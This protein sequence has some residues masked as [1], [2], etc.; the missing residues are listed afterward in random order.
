MPMFMTPEGMF[1]MT[2]E[3]MFIIGKILL[4]FMLISLISSACLIFEKAIQPSGKLFFH[5]AEIVFYVSVLTFVFVMFSVVIVIGFYIV[6]Y[7]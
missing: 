2:P 1:F 7:C 6:F 4:F 3:G 5:I